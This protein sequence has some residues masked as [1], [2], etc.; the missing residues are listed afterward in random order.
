VLL[1]ML[2]D[3]RLH[4]SG[5]AILAPHLTEETAAGPGASDAQVQAPNR[6][7]RCRAG[8]EAGCSGGHPKAAHT[9]LGARPSTPSGRS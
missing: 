6:G 8:T 2:G 5:I 3:G 7:A 1:A 9:T 4:L